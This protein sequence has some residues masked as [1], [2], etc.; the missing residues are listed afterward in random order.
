MTVAYDVADPHASNLA[1][2]QRKG[3]QGAPGAGLRPALTGKRLPWT[4]QGS[5]SVT[6][7][8]Q[9]TGRAARLAPIEAQKLQLKKI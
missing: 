8:S 1:E 3:G 9:L 5:G 4:S 7:A 6:G 2:G